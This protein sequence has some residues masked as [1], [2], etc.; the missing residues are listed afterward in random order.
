M[1]LARFRAWRSKNTLPAIEPCTDIILRFDWHEFFRNRCQFSLPEEKADNL[2][3]S[4]L[5]KPRPFCVDYDSAQSRIELDAQP[6]ALSAIGNN[7]RYLNSTE[8]TPS[9]LQVDS[10]GHDIANPHPISLKGN[11][12][13]C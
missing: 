5:K 10:S 7:C 8:L 11:W 2:P 13:R 12:Q 9:I 4:L 1:L 6:L 3:R